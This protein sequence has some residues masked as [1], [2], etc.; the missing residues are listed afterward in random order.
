MLMHEWLQFRDR[1]IR[2]LSDA[3]AEAEADEAEELEDQA[4][5]DEADVAEADE[6]LP[7]GADL[8]PAD[9]EDLSLPAPRPGPLPTSAP[10]P[11]APAAPKP[12]RPRPPTAVEGRAAPR[13]AREVLET[14]QPSADVRT[15][16]EAVL[17]RQRR[18][19]LDDEEAAEARRPRRAAETREQ[20]VSRLLDPTLSLQETALLLGVCPTT[21]RRYTNRGVM[22]C[23]R[24]PGNQ[25]RFKLSDVLEFMERR[26][27]GEV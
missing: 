8:E 21:V 3:Q 18:L 10:R 15:R 9:A 12:R 11:A 5:A 1:N 13:T 26:E 16:L 2:R 7:P 19:P 20:L 25:R 14:L 24:T 23:F 27:H 6:A 4:P 22:Q 17:A